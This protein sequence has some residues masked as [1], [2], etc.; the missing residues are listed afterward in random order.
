MVD[1]LWYI[2]VFTITGHVKILTYLLNLLHIYALCW[3]KIFAN[4]NSEFL[5]KNY[6]KKNKKK[7]N[8]LK[9]G[10]FFYVK[11]FYI[12]GRF[13]IK[14]NGWKLFLWF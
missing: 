7:S 1:E 11:P 9:S 4:V 8:Q 12:I 6:E 5:F 2:C 10:I 14:K 13:C 3:Y